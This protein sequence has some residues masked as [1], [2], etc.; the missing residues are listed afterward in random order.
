[1]KPFPVTFKT[2]IAILV[3][4]FIIL[5]GTPIFSQPVTIDLIKGC[6]TKG[7]IK[8]SDLAE[9]ISYVKLETMKDCLIDDHTSSLFFFGDNWFIPQ[10]GILRFDQD[11]KF[12]NKIS[13]RGKGPAEYI[14]LSGVGFNAENNHVYLINRLTGKAL[15]FSLDGKFIGDVKNASTNS[16][17]Y[18]NQYFVNIFPIR[19]QFKSDAEISF[20]FRQ[21]N[22][23]HSFQDAKL[24]P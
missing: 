23:T 24:Q 8:L 12:L 9:K 18:N 20:E 15:E 6:E 22:H 16:V 17:L 2:R 5:S 14:E 7:T 10:G 21:R 19:A 1:M 4:S 11:G 3:M 13:G